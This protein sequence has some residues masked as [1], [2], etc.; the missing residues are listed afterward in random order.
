VGRN[1]YVQKMSE[2]VQS[3]VSRGRHNY[4]H[5]QRRIYCWDCFHNGSEDNVDADYA[6][7]ERLAAMVPIDIEEM[8]FQ[9]KAVEIRYKKHAVPVE[10]RHLF[11]WGNRR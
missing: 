8:K 9:V 6:V 10:Y 2:L 11:D 3:C 7:A 1:E 4:V 5:G